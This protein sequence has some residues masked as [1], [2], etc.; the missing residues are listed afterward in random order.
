VTTP[1]LK[2]LAVVIGFLAVMISQRG[3]GHG[4]ALLIATATAV[5]FGLIRIIRWL[6]KR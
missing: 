1:E 5:L 6:A 4:E 2:I 3:M